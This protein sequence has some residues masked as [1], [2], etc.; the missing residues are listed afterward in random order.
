MKLI[1]LKDQQQLK[2][3]GIH[4]KKSTLYFW[5]HKRKYPELFVK[6][7]GRVFVDSDEFFKL[8]EKTKEKEANL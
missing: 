5:H 7:G 2:A 4:F 6:I 8:A 3:N 1:P